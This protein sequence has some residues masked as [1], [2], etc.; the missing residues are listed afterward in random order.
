MPAL[1][2]SLQVAISI[3]EKEPLE[4]EIIHG[5][6]LALDFFE[7]VNSLRLLIQ[8]GTNFKY[9]PLLNAGSELFEK[10]RQKYSGDISTSLQSHC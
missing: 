1:A 4:L 7:V 6:I 9:H 3:S 2:A 8:D 5:L 10:R